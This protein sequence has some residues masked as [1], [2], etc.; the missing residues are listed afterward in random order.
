MTIDLPPPACVVATA[1]TFGVDATVAASLSSQFLSV[2]AECAVQT[3]EA[4]C[5]AATP[6][7]S[8]ALA[9]TITSANVQVTAAA[10]A[11]PPP[12]APSAAAL[13][14]VKPSVVLLAVGATLLW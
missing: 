12:P 11:T 7:D 13:H 1:T 10:N 14:F 3:S 2:Q 6:A 9:A 8:T 5:A 4:L